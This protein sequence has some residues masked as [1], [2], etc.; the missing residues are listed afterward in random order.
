MIATSGSSPSRL[1]P[2]CYSFGP[3]ARSAPYFERSRGGGPPRV[4]DGVFIITSL[5]QFFVSEC[6]VYLVFYA[7]STV[8][9]III[10][11]SVLREEDGNYVSC[12]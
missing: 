2:V 5:R 9:V 7:Q 4:R 1:V 3:V 10:R 11:E 6:G 8:M 12:E